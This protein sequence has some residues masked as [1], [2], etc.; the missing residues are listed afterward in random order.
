M[1]RLINNFRW[2]YPKSL[3]RNLEEKMIFEIEIRPQSHKSGS[4]KMDE[5]Q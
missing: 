4:L 1:D 2:G 5:L 3:G